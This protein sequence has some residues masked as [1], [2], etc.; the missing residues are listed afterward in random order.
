MRNRKRVLFVLPQLKQGGAE[1]V[2][3]NIV[4]G[5]DRS[6]FMPCIAW[7]HGERLYPFS[8]LNNVPMYNVN[9]QAGLMPEQ[10]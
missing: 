9:K 10:H 4:K 5:I 2:V 1:R 7:F 3:L 6:R 8:E